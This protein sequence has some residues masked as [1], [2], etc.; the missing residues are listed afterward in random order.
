[1][2]ESKTVCPQC[3]KDVGWLAGAEVKKCPDCGYEFRS[4]ETPLRSGFSLR[5]VPGFLLFLGA[6]VAPGVVMFLGVSSPFAHKTDLEVF[7][8]IMRFPG[9]DE[10]TI[11]GPIISG[12]LCGVWLGSAISKRSGLRIVLTL[13][14]APVCWL[15][16]LLFCFLGCGLGRG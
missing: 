13:I 4:G 16:S 12:L 7:G 6:L 5:S 8:N 1:M 11:Y 3:K 15:V 14:L 9:Q 2:P 10:L